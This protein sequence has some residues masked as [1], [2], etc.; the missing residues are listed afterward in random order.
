[1]PV[2]NG[3]TGTLIWKPMTLDRY[4]RLRA[5]TTVTITESATA[6]GTDSGMEMVAAVI[7]AGGAAWYLACSREDDGTCKNNGRKPECNDCGGNSPLGR[8]SSGNQQNCPC[9]EKNC[10]KD[11]PPNCAAQDCSRT[12]QSLKCGAEGQLKGY[13]CCP[14]EAPQCDADDCKGDDK[15]RYQADKFKGCGCEAPDFGEQEVSFTEPFPEVAS[16]ETLQKQAKDALD[17]IWGGDRSK[18]PGYQ[19]KEMGPYCLHG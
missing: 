2:I 7:F 1:T 9:Q 4:K 14:A 5:S 11:S 8:C 13:K 12:N 10:P 19:K 6:S 16:S 18:M 3:E 17:K 15:E